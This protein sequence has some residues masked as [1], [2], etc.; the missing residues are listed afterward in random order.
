MKNDQNERRHE[1]P[2]ESSVE[3]DFPFGFCAMSSG[4]KQGDAKSIS[5][6]LV[7]YEHRHSQPNINLQGWFLL[8]VRHYPM[9]EP[10]AGTLKP[11][12]CPFATINLPLYS[13][14]L[15]FK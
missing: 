3:R 10:V 7:A 9:G 15:S 4:L 2:T 5:F 6:M 1:Q 13:F 8:D 11:G 14:F 12:V